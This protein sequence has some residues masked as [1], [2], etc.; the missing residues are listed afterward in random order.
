MTH[1]PVVIV[2][3][4]PGGL[5]TALALERVGTRTLVLERAPQIRA[6]GAG[7]TLQVNAMRMLSALGLVEQ[8]RAAGEE[9]RGGRLETH[10]GVC[11]SSLPFD[12]ASTRYGVPGIAIHRAALARLLVAELPRPDILRCGVEVVEVQPRHDGIRVIS[13][14]GASVEGRALVGADGIRSAVRS[15]VW[16]P[17]PVRYAGYTCWRGVAPIS[18]PLGPGL[19]AERW[20][21]GRRFGIVPIGPE[22]TYW[23]ATQNAEPGG[24]DGEDPR[25][26]LLERFSDFAAPVAELLEATPNSAILRNDIEDLER[27]ESWTRGPVTLLGD[28][29]HAMTPNMGQGACQ[30]IEDAVVLAD[31]MATTGSVEEGFAS[32]EARRRARASSFVAR[33]RSMG[34]AGQWESAVARALRNTVARLTPSSVMMRALDRDWR[35]DVPSLVV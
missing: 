16:G 21:P 34:R 12:D 6:V 23:F 25:S 20:G 4:G 10:E 1:R 29:A 15:A 32:Y 11:L 8:V 27:L 18:G 26:E 13:S 5:V 14:D 2:G 28:A 24:R 3:G 19:T 22:S 9:L 17:V 31:S 30:A 35:V 7:L 33:S